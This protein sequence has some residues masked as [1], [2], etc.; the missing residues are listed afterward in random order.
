MDETPLPSAPSIAWQ[1]AEFLGRMGHPARPG[2]DPD[3][4]LYGDLDGGWIPVRIDSAIWARE[5][6]RFARLTDPANHIRGVNPDLSLLMDYLGAVVFAGDRIARSA[7]FEDLD[8]VRDPA[9]VSLG[10]STR[11]ARYQ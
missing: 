4:L 5:Q 3:E 11:R 9:H 7:H 1:F 2:A 10:S 8:F 6:P